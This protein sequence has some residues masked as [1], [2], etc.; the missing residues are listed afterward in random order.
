LA[1]LRELSSKSRLAASDDVLIWMSAEVEADEKAG[2]M[3]GGW[4]SKPVKGGKKEGK[5]SE[6]DSRDELGDNTSQG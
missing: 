5:C 4:P 3:A 2:L 1:D 6:N